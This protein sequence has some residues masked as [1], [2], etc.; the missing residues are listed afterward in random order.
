MES[1]IGKDFKTVWP[2]TRRSPSVTDDEQI[3][4][5]FARM[6]EAHARILRFQEERRRAANRKR[7]RRP[8]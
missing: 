3:R 7:L 4:R 6:D 2:L 1:L 5:A 8:M